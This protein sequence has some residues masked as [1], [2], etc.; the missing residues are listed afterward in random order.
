MN[1]IT[2]LGTNLIIHAYL[3]CYNEEKIIKNTL[4][5]YSQ[6]CTKIFVLDNMSTDQSCEIASQYK[7]VTVIKWQNNGFI[8]ESLYVSLKNLDI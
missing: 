5:Y 1:L 8:D 3:L 4:D 7:N 6:F 2:F